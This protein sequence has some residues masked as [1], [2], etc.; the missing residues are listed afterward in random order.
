MAA[1]IDTQKRKDLKRSSIYFSLRWKLLV[2]FT[3][4]FS[5]VFAIAFYWFYQFATNAALTRIQDDLTSTLQ[6]G[7][8]KVNTDE[9]LSLASDGKPNAAGL[10]WAA[11]GDASD[12]AEAA[13]LTQTA[14]DTYGQ[15]LPNGFSDDP[16]YQNQLNWLD[17]IHKIEPRAWPYIYIPG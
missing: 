8:A 5:V 13:K 4:I 16:R 10:A 6:G 17:I 11:V 9:L 14:I 12:D 1:S 2:G 15:A 7:A 3:L